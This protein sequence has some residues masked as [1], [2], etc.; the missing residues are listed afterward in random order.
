[1]NIYFHI[2]ELNRDAV[3]ASALRLKFAA[4]GHRLIYGNR[5]GNRLLKYF[6]NAFDVILMPRPHM[7]Y[8]NWGDDW[9]NWDSRIVMLSTESLGIICKDHLVMARTLLEK[10]Y[11]EGNK[12]YIERIDAFCFWGK[13]QLQ[14]INDYASEVSYKCHVVGHP[15]HD[16][17]CIKQESTKN[18]SLDTCKK[19]VGIITRAVGLNDYFNR[20]PMEVYSVLF[21]DHFKYEFHNKKTGEY[22]V[23]KR[24]QTAPSSALVVQAIDL[25]NSLKI[26]KKLIDEGHQISIRVHPKENSSNWKSLLKSCNLPVEVSDE[27]M[28]ISDWVSKVDYLVGPPSTSFYDALMLGKTPISIENLDLRRK[29]SI[30]ELWEDHNRLM[31]YVFKPNSIEELVDI[32]NTGNVTKNNEEITRILEEEANYPM[33]ANSLNNVLDVCTNIAPKHKDRKI[34]LFIFLFV[35]RVFFQIWR[36]KSKLSNRKE[37]SAMFVIGKKESDFIDGLCLKNK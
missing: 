3:V 26:I 8:D 12:T 14:A 31:P 6:H 11:F 22:L 28:P 2:D 35:R 17:V 18:S 1:M 20:S 24:P 9:I 13:K 30:G 36:L 10:D 7:L 27:K 32:V 16:K 34:V 19:K 25:E 21:N 15:R 23:S 37:N 4:K 29:E 33:C 5:V